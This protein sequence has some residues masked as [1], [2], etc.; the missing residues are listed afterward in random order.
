MNTEGRA[1]G[2]AWIATAV[3]GA[4]VMAL[5]GLT[6]AMGQGQAGAA[7]AGAQSLDF[8]PTGVP[9]GP[10]R[11]YPE[12]RLGVEHNDNIFADPFDEVSDT[13]I[14]VV[15]SLNLRSDWNRHAVNFGVEARRVEYLDQ[16]DESSTQVNLTG[17]GLFEA[18]LNN[19]IAANGGLLFGVQARTDEA[20]PNTALEPVEFNRTTFGLAARRTF[21]RV[22]LEVAGRRVGEDFDDVFARG[23]DPDTLIELD[24]DFRDRDAVTAS[25]RADYALSPSI[26]VFVTGELTNTDY[27][28]DENDGVL[29]RDSDDTR[30]QAGVDFEISRVMNGSVRAGVQDRD[31]DSDEI[32]DFD[33]TTAEGSIEWFPTQLTTATF[34]GSRVLQDAGIFDTAG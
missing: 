12:L 1:R 23:D 27:N 24:Q 28:L 30:Y 9:A 14:T 16:S 7:R 33:G 22:R 21:E 6:P 18:G 19:E 3:A 4:G 8:E 15:P 31:Y 26:A 25:L 32:A 13:A 34:T 11:A 29:D 2:R 10:L 20:T 5:A 17:D